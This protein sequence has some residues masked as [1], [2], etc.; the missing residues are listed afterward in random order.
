M[1]KKIIFYITKKKS[2]K[3]DFFFNFSI[4]NTPLLN[5]STAWIPPCFIHLPK[6]GKLPKV[7]TREYFDLQKKINHYISSFLGEKITSIIDN[8]EFCIEFSDKNLIHGTLGDNLKMEV[9]HKELILW[10]LILPCSEEEVLFFFDSLQ[11]IFTPG[12]I[13]GTGNR[14]KY[15]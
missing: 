9:G 8:V 4:K 5:F 10:D 2:V 1:N 11:I 14:K 6:T 13:P 15:D 12:Q 7:D 3:G